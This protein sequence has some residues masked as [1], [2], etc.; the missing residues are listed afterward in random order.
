MKCSIRAGAWLLA[1]CSLFGAVE[2]ASE[3]NP[4]IDGLQLYGRSTVENYQLDLKA[5]QWQWLQAKG[6]LKLGVTSV[7]YPPFDFTASGHKYEGITAD[8]MGIVSQLLHIPVQISRYDNRAA[9]IQALKDG[10]VDLLGTANGFEEAD[11]DLA[12]STAY[13]DDQPVLVTRNNEDAA[14]TSQM[15]GKKIAMLYHYLPPDKVRA[16][17]PDSDVQLYPSTLSAIGAVAFGKADV[18]LGDAIGANYLIGMNYLNNVHIEDYSRMEGRRFAFAV[19]AQNTQLL[20]IVNAALASIPIAESITIRRRWSSYEI[21]PPAQRRLQFTDSEQRWLAQHARVTVS[22]M[23]DFLPISFFDNKGALRGVSADVLAKISLRTGLV[24]DVVRGASMARQID[25]LHNGKVDMLAALT[26]SSER[27]GTMRFTRPYLSTPYVLISRK[28]SSSP[29]TL[30]DMPGKRLAMIRGMYLVD[31]VTTHYP[32]VKIVLADNAAELM[33]MVARGE[34]E[35]GVNSLLIANYMIAQQYRETLQVTSSVGVEPA[36]FSFVTNRQDPELHSILEK[37][38][39]NI[40]PEEMAEISSRWRSEAFI[41]ENFWS[42]NRAA[43]VQGF[44]IAGVL[45]A[46]AIIWITYL[47]RLIRRREAAERALNNQLE[48]QRVLIDETPHPIYVRDRQGHMLTCNASYL[49]VFGLDHEAVL[50]KRV[51]ESV[52]SDSE[53]GVTYHEEYLAVLNDGIAK[54]ADRK[55]VFPDGTVLSIYHWMLPYKDSEG[56]VIGVIAGWVDISERE[57]LLGMVQEA[58]RA[59]STF[60]AT[61]SHEIR[62]PLN[63]VI[64]MLELVLKK[65]DQGMLDRS[66][67]EVASGAAHGLLDLIG[68]ILDISRIE[69]GK[70]SL[71]PGRAN[72]AEL[73]RSVARVFEGLAQQKGLQ[74]ELAVDPRVDCDVAI[75]PVRFKQVISNLVSNAIKFT[76]QGQV[77]LSVDALSQTCEHTLSIRVR[78]E[79]SGQGISVDDQKRLFSPFAQAESNGQ[80][81][82]S[83]SG[84]GLVISRTLCEMMDG[85]LHLTSTLGEGT[86]VDVLLQF[87][88]LEPLAADADTATEASPQQT[89]QILV[90]D[91]YSANRLLLSKQLGYLGH[92]LVEAR[93]GEQGL[94]AWRDRRFDVV[95]TDCNMPVMDGYAL[96]RAIRAEEQERG[97][98]RCLIIGFTANAQPDEKDRCLQAGMD[99]CLFKPISLDVLQQRLD[100]VDAADGALADVQ[101]TPAIETLIDFSALEKLVRGDQEA[102]NELLD[103]LATSNQEDSAHLAQSLREQDVE[104]LAEL[105]HKLKGGAR[106]VKARQLIMACETLEAACND[107]SDEQA[108]QQ[109]ASA[110]E[111]E[112]SSLAEALKAYHSSH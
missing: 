65:S 80:S 70:L 23:E 106:I 26:L 20:P 45:L 50:G 75:D 34:V 8:Y 61:M 2:A 15:S 77:R 68:D 56:D 110:L 82:R 94:R 92:K 87:A 101:S 74:L 46:A 24:F 19:A 57:K 73:V 85:Q 42:R 25:N 44:L 91:D 53:A 17:Y 76:E 81:S 28:D 105:A 36:R 112:I 95:I 109:A 86:Q 100:R 31:Y 58:N 67:I 33:A 49:E 55:L 63:A 98:E 84:L 41:D 10:E 59:K 29:S 5:P 7:N 62:T 27:E 9:A 3:N 30:D 111:R 83:G 104:A 38:L 72:L 51:M 32:Q 71:T 6:V 66:A 108:V 40:S 4:G 102:M 43:I 97:L 39:L 99:D 103:D 21:S 96:A 37:A 1:L 35:A 88:V 79:D 78:V 60:L 47:R 90:V 22:A 11:P 89:L 18:Y 64:G 93:D 13:A 48:F 12:L 52:F 69:S 107:G 54:I 14:L 16:F